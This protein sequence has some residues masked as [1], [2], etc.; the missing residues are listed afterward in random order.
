LILGQKEV[1][2]KTISFRLFGS[3]ETTTMSIEEFKKYINSK[4][5]ELN[6][7]ISNHILDK[8]IIDNIKY[9]MN[10]EDICKEM[11]QN[12][13]KIINE[14]SASDLVKFILDHFN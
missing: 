9:L 6:N 5:K 2:E 10:N 7:F 13:K 1:D 11:I 8:E 14:N 12:Q 3:T 4:P